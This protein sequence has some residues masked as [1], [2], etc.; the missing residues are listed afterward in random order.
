MATH[1]PAQVSAN[2]SAEFDPPESPHYVPLEWHQDVDNFDDDDAIA[3]EGDDWTYRIC[4]VRGE[5]DQVIGYRISGGDFES[6]D[7]VFGSSLID[8]KPGE[9][10]LA[11]AKAVADVD[12]AAR[13]READVLLNDALGGWEDDEG[14]R[15]HRNEHGYLVFRIDEPVDEIEVVTTLRDHSADYDPDARRVTV[16]LRTILP[17]VS[18]YGD[19]L[20]ALRHI[21]RR[22]Q[23]A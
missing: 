2:G 10:T 5:A 4:P 19:A 16:C 12:Y 23:K 14:P 18:G 17:W 3:A 7:N 1:H 8:G 20:E 6:G 13:Y 22:A 11:R 9:R 15:V 21:V